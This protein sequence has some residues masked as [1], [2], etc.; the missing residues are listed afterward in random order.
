MP[1]IL[2]VGGSSLKDERPGRHQSGTNQQV[3]SQVRPVYHVALKIVNE[4]WLKILRCPHIHNSYVLRRT[5]D[6]RIL[7]C[8][9]TAWKR[10]GSALGLHCYRCWRIAL[11]SRPKRQAAALPGKE[12]AV[13]PNN[14]HK[15][16]NFISIRGRET[17]T[18]SELQATRRA[19]DH[20]TK[21]ELKLLQWLT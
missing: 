21:M 18:T 5:F 1:T 14:Q 19:D 13:Y 12:P 10:A 11:H 6:E 8:V 3:F 16:Y 15:M 2:S 20:A 7:Q 4:L 17:I 9:S